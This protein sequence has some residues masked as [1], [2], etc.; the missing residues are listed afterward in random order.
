M[1]NFIRIVLPTHVPGTTP[2]SVGAQVLGP[3]GEKIPGVKSVVI[4]LEAGQPITAELTMHA[5]LEGDITALEDTSRRFA[6]VPSLWD[7]VRALFALPA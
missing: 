1:R 5:T 4:R 3:G 2:T 7:R 6:K